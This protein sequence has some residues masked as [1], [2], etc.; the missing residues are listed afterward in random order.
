MGWNL[1]KAQKKC[2]NA[3]SVV[4]HA[5]FPLN[6]ELLIRPTGLQ[7]NETG[8]A[9]QLTS[10]GFLKRYDETV[11]CGKLMGVKNIFP[12]EVPPCL[13]NPNFTTG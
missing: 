8:A 5:C 2:R 9:G 4:W 13:A 7:G 1:A 12:P 6:K 10:V 11:R 3:I